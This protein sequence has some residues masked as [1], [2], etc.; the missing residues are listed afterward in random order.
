MTMTDKT[1][2][3]VAALTREETEKLISPETFAKI[4]ELEFGKTIELKPGELAS[5]F[6]SMG[7]SP[8]DVKNVTV[9]KMP[10]SDSND[11]DEDYDDEDMDG[12]LAALTGGRRI[13][14]QPVAEPSDPRVIEILEKEP[15][16]RTEEECEYVQA[17]WLKRLRENATPEMV[18]TCEQVKL[19]R[20][21]QLKQAPGV[22]VSI[23][24]VNGAGLLAIEV[25]FIGILEP[26]EAKNVAPALLEPFVPKE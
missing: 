20:K 21:Y 24:G 23:L 9:V 17:D 18:A 2:E 16:D 11:D 8:D 7:L 3:H 25:D 4:D 1:T 10:A 14:M 15:D 5:F 6:E 22:P 13:P 19:W 12:L 26:M